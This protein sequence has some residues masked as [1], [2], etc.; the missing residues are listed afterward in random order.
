[1]PCH[2]PASTL[3]CDWPSWVP[4]AP[5]HTQYLHEGLARCSGSVGEAQQVSMCTHI[6]APAPLQKKLPLMA[7]S[8]TMAESFKELDPDSSMG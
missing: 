1:M 8:T 6:P 7:L 4:S 2:H 5:V 3:T